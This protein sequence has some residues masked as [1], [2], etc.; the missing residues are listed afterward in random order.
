[1]DMKQQLKSESLK[2]SLVYKKMRS[3]TFVGSQL[4][5]MNVILY[6]QFNKILSSEIENKCRN[7]GMNDILMKPISKSLLEE[8]LK[9]NK[10]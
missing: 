5:S 7:C 3:T 8:K 1:M 9:Q 6:H 10:R 2:M 4:K